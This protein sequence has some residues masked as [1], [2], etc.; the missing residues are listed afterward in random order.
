MKKQDRLNQ[1]EEMLTLIE[2]WQESGQT[3]QS[4]CKDHNLAFSKFY[5]WRKRYR[6]GM[7]ESTFLPVDIS[8]GLSTSIEIRYPDGVVLQL[9]PSTRISVLKQLLTR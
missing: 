8:Q 4:F 1:Q 5:Y 6:R 3:Q 9:P 2:Q 7:D